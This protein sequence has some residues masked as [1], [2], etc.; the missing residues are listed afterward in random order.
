MPMPGRPE[1]QHRVPG[2]VP[3]HRPPGMPPGMPM[4]GMGQRPFNGPAGV[5]RPMME[6]QRMMAPN[7]QM[8]QMQNQPGMPLRPP[9]MQPPRM[10]MQRPNQ[11]VMM[12]AIP[13]GLPQP[14]MQGLPGQPV[15]N[16]GMWQCQWLNC[17]F[18]C[19]L[20]LL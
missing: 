17:L 16:Q 9:M 15:M 4:N 12:N 14:G 7:Q 1:F 10:E 8:S 20:K 11:P 3:M 5:Q 6:Q 13:Q 19:V 2:V 18:S